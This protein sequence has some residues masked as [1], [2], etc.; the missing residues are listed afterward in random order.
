MNAAR[1][2]RRDDI[3]AVR[4][5]GRSVRHTLFAMRARPN[6]MAVLRLAVSAP[7]T[8]GR[9][10]KRNRVRRRVREAFRLAA[11][12]LASTQGHDVLVVARAAAEGV[13]ASALREAARAALAGLADEA[14]AG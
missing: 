13:S 4:N 12:E 10:V 8:L 7:R 3:T 1:L 9:A 14:R 5:E 11:T 2:R 6:T